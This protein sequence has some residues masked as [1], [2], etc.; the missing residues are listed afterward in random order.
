MGTPRIDEK[1]VE[2]VEFG[3]VPLRA[4]DGRGGPMREVGLDERLH[5]S[6]V[7]E[8]EGRGGP[9]GDEHVVGVDVGG[10]HHRQG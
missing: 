8:V 4:V 6:G 5:L 3:R 10:S 9:E 1:T 7:G 2:D